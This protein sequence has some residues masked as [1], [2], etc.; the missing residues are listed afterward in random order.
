MST[1]DAKAAKCP[2]ESI[3]VKQVDIYWL[4]AYVIAISSVQRPRHLKHFGA[5]SGSER[6]PRMRLIV[7]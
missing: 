3:C 2:R 7:D 1:L 6:T 4:A 5:V